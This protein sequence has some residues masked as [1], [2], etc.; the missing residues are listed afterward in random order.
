MPSLPN[1]MGSNIQIQR[2]GFYGGDMSHA[3]LSLLEF[4]PLF[5]DL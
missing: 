3:R 5:E 2:L 1:W 4:K